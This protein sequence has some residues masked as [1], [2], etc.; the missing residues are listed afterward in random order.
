MLFRQ[1]VAAFG[2]GLALEVLGSP[3]LHAS[4]EAVLKREVPSTHAVHE[5]HTSQMAQ[6]WAKRDRVPRNTMLPMRI[7]LKQTNLDAG[8]DRLMAM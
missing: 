8:H 3:I 5:R 1:L 4:D 7:G 6:Y 2:L